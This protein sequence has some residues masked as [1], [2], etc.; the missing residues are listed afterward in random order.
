MGSS[1]TIFLVYR[2]AA[3]TA[4]PVHTTKNYGIRFWRRLES[5]MGFKKRGLSC[6]RRSRSGGVRPI[7]PT[8]IPASNQVSRLASTVLNNRA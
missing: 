3:D 1:P 4:V 6:T 2:N 7:L 5:E 8:P